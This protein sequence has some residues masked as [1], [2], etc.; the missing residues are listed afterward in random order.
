MVYTLPKCSPLRQA[1]R[2]PRLT[3]GDIMLFGYILYGADITFFC[4][5]ILQNKVSTVRIPKEAFTLIR[6][7][8]TIAI[9]TFL[10]KCS[11]THVIG[12]ARDIIVVIINIISWPISRLHSCSHNQQF[13]LAGNAI[14][15]WVICICLKTLPIHCIFE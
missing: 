7:W 8:L 4:I 15:V 9:A 10:G 6:I 2:V 3:A 13:S 14:S 1:G 5:I 12:L 11:L